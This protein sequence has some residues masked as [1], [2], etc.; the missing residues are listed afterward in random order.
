MSME[1]NFEDVDLCVEDSMEG[2][3]TQTY[4]ISSGVPHLCVALQVLACSLI[5]L[6]QHLSIYGFTAVLCNVHVLCSRRETPPR[7]PNFS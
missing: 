4:P 1:A 3:G 2:G 7:S 6:V 5:R